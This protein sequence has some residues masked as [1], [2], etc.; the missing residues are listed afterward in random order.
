M[1]ER[2]E[3]LAKKVS[4][5]EGIIAD[6]LVELDKMYMAIQ[7]ILDTYEHNY[8]PE[9]GKAYEYANTV[10]AEATCSNEAKWA[11]E[12]MC[13]YKKIMWLANV[14]RDY[15]YLAIKNCENVY[16]RGAENE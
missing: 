8:I 13:G 15:C 6:N 2:E 5:Y 1:S 7:E 3:Q 16:Q 4:D 12:Y 9:T 14:A 11:W 10:H